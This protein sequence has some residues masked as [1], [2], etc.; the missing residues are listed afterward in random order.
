MPSSSLTPLLAFVAV[1]ALIPIALWLLRRSGYAGAGQDGLMRT[2]SS[3]ALSPSQRV[4]VVE[5]GQGAT[6]R[7]L[8]LGVTNESINCLTQLD[9]PAEVPAALRTPQAHTV[10]QLIAKWRS[11]RGPADGGAANE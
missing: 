2:V 8:V 1:V 7:W 10:N 3:L 4:V 11:G 9:A 5:L 6:A